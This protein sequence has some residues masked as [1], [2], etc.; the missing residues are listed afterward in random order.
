[1][2]MREPFQRVLAL[3]VP[4]RAAAILLADELAEVACL[5]DVLRR[6]RER[7]RAHLAVLGERVAEL[8]LLDRADVSVR[9]RDQLL[10]AEPAGRL[11][12]AD[13]PLRVFRAR[14]AV[15]AVRDRL[16]AELRDRVARVDALRAALV[17]EVAARAIPDPVRFAVALE[18]LDLRA[19]A[20]VAD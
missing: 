5:L 9:L 3:D 14:V 20:R 7:D 11:G 2:R 19:A 18:P 15:D 8:E 1:M 13:E 4:E 6:V 12:R 17:A 10:L 16:G